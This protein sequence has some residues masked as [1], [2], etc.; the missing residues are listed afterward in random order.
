[1][2]QLGGLL[3]SIAS[4][5]LYYGVEF[6]G[7]SWTLCGRKSISGDLCGRPETNPHLAKVR[8]AGSNP[9]FRSIVAGQRVCFSTQP[10]EVLS[11][12]PLRPLPLRCL[13]FEREWSEVKRVAGD[14]PIVLI[15]EELAL[16][17]RPSTG[18]MSSTV[19]RRTAVF[20]RPFTL[21][22]SVDIPCWFHRRWLPWRRT[23]G[24]QRDFERGR[25]HLAT[26]V[27]AG[28]LAVQAGEDIRNRSSCL[29]VA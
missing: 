24:H 23:R 2:G 3:D 20:D 14:R 11:T 9:V 28:R 4:R 26:H 22:S 29:R 10:W 16:Q 1:M 15:L 5:P 25:D 18:N 27:H 19:E 21:F 7:P 6:D 17:S 13:C 12:R 8:V